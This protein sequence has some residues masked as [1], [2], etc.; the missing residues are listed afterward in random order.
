MSDLVRYS[1]CGCIRLESTFDEEP[2]DIKRLL[3][4]TNRI[5]EHHKSDRDCWLKYNQDIVVRFKERGDRN[6]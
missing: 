1:L 2:L 5:K 6:A 4:F 3:K